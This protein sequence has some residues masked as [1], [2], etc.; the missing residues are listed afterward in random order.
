MIR[1]LPPGR[2]RSPAPET[3]PA[4][5]RHCVL[6]DAV[7]AGR[8]RPPLDAVVEALL[9]WFVD[10]RVLETVAPSVPARASVR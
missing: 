7:R 6:A 5:G 10:V 2:R 4:P 8:Y 3:A 1:Q 9:P